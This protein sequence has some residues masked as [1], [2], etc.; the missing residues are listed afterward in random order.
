MGKNKMINGKTDKTVLL[1][2]MTK[3]AIAYQME[4]DRLIKN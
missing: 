4:F 2:L 1:L 3:I